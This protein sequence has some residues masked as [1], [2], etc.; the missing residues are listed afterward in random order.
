MSN[1]DGSSTLK[2]TAPDTILIADDQPLVRAGI[3]VLVSGV[4]GDA[5]FLEVDDGDGLLRTIAARPLVRLALIDLQMPRMFGGLR[6][7]EI[8]Q[9]QLDVPLVLLSSIISLDL[10]RKMLGLPT[11]YA[12]LAKSASTAAVHGAIEAALARRKF[13]DPPPRVSSGR[14]AAR[15]TPRQEEIHA[16]LRQ[17]MSNK[18]IAAELGISEGTVKNHLTEI[19][20][21][22]RA[23]NRT[24]AAQLEIAAD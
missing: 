12:F 16:L 2:A 20:K 13:A 11:V 21:V 8:A 5:H 15:L 10:S 24:Q 17:G 19:F 4:L 22:L 7:S 3:K 18:V 6:L 14:A 1:A 23:S 9:A